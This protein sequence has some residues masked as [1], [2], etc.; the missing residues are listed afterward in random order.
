MGESTSNPRPLKCVMKDNMIK[1]MLFKKLWKLR[2]AED[3][4]RALSI[5]SDQ[6]KKEREEEWVK[7]PW[8]RDIKTRKHN[9][10][11]NN[12]NNN[13]SNVSCLKHNELES[14]YT[15]ADSF[16]N[17]FSEFKEIIK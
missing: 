14:L 16:I 3:K 1:T 6:T 12:N 13:K 7:P 5:Q 17:K 11:N 8:E 4:F 15:N 2:D 10:N 9:N